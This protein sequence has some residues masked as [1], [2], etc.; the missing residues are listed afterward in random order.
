MPMLGFRQRVRDRRR[1]RDES[2]DRGYQPM[3]TLSGDKA[4]PFAWASTQECCPSP[5]AGKG[6]DEN[7]GLRLCVRGCVRHLRTGQVIL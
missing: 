7:K 1:C 6:P 2:P 5:L 4:C 3:V